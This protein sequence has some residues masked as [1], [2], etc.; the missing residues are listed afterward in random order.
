MKENYSLD[1]P[2]NTAQLQREKQNFPSN[3][4]VNYAEP[5]EHIN[6]AVMEQNL[7][8]CLSIIDNQV[9]K[10]YIPEL[11]TCP[12]VEFD[13][14]MLH[15]ISDDAKFI[16][17]FRITELVYQEDEFSVHKLATVYHTLSNKPCTLVLM[18]QSDG[19]KNDF[20][21]GVRARGDNSTGTMKQKL[22]QSL[23]GLFPGSKTSEY[24]KEN[25]EKNLKTFVSNV[26]CVSSVTCLADYKHNKESFE[27]KEFLQGLEKFIY[28]T[29]GKAFT[30]IFIAN[31]LMHQELTDVRSDFE[32]VYTL[33]SPFATMQYNYAANQS[34]GMSESNTKGNSETETKGSSFG[35][36]TSESNAHSLQ[37]GTNQ[38]QAYTKGKNSSETNGVTHTKG[39]TDTRS[40]SATITKTNGTSETSSSNFNLSFFH[41]NSSVTHS[42][43]TSRAI[44][45]GTS[46]SESASES[47]ARN[48]T[49]GIN[50]S[51]SHTTGTSQ[52][53]TDTATSTNGTQS[54]VSDSHSSA[55][56]SSV[57]NALSQTLGGSQSTTLNVQNKALIDTLER[58]DKQLKRLDE[59]ESIGMWDFAAYFLGESSAEA[60]TV[61]SL[62]YSLISG[63]QT[64]LE[65]SGVNTW[66]DGKSVQMLTKYITNFVH[67]QFRYLLQEDF[68]IQEKILDAT[69]LASTNELAIQLGLPRKS[70]IGLPVIKHADFAQEVL[71]NDYCSKNEKTIFIGNCNH[72]GEKTQ[73]PVKLDLQSLAMHT[74]VTGS[75]GAGKSNTIYQILSQLYKNEIKFLIIEPA[76]GEYKELFGEMDN[77]QV[78]GTNPLLNTVLRINPFSFPKGIHIYEHLDRLVEI[79][80]VCWPMYAAMPAVLKEAIER[81]YIKAG[82]NLKVSKNKYSEQLFPN[83]IDV[84]QQIDEVMESSQY[85][86]ENKSNYK[87][88]LSTRIKSL[89][90]GVNSLIFTSD[91]LS[92]ADLFDK[93]VI[94]DL[95]RIG[96]S[97]TKSLIMGLLVMKL[98]EHRMAAAD[99][100]DAELNHVTILEEAHNLLKRTSTEQSADSSNLLGKSVEMLT[101]AIAEMRTYGEGFII[102]D[103]APGL[104]DMSVIRNTNTKIIM[105]LPDFS[106]RELVGRSASLNDEQLLELAKLPK[107]VAAVYQNDWLEAV[108]CDVQKYCPKQKFHKKKVLE[109]NLPEKIDVKGKIIGSIIKGKLNQLVNSLNVDGILKANIFVGAKCLLYKFAKT[110][111]TKKNVAEIT[112]ELFSAQTAFASLKGQHLEIKEQIQFLSEQLSPSLKQFTKKD[113][114]SIL[115]YILLHQCQLADT[116][117]NKNLYAYIEQEKNKLENK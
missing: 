11:H 78:Y 97:E 4:R 69:V 9:M 37:Q 29:Q 24:L 109:E 95:S 30:A 112:Y 91:E 98:Q 93:N 101:N 28:S 16:Q 3:D 1:T 62:Y 86:N 5:A 107:G 116:V 75:T 32:R 10:D 73:I 46:H 47:I 100:M 38:S 23:M 96:S 26:G 57:T 84:L 2:Y 70:V 39:I 63:N 104:L 58:I 36:N 13:E 82:W 50:S 90:T 33:L 114:Y 40:K 108:L 34:F 76:K 113:A 67:P 14:N 66:T 110:F 17:F 6:F 21:L 103:Q 53:E 74:F 31:N 102:V 49:K 88:A 68:S 83:F 80:N 44:T 51:V 65:A 115:Y 41:R 25:L 85:S 117:D 60:E 61:A 42:S 77:V 12:V 43:S 52:S 15:K 89:T 45:R 111:L 59:C 55:V 56:N 92:T 94:I 8:N 54:S 27:N 20:Y 35:I 79:F 19:T 48:L 18:I 106:D 22:Q 99:K 87:G 64:G 7:Q 81:S 72:L 105:R 71:K